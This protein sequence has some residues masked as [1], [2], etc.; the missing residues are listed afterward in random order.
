MDN[1]KP[2]YTKEELKE[3]EI[4]ATIDGKPVLVLNSISCE[5]EFS[6]ASNTKKE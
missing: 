3:A 2:K 1:K 4:I 6:E 5:Q